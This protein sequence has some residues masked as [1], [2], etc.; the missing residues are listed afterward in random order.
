MPAS[1]VAGPIYPVHQPMAGEGEA[2]CDVRTA[3]DLLVASAVLCLVAVSAAFV[4]LSVRRLST[5]RRLAVITYV[6][7]VVCYS[8]FVAL[9]AFRSA[10]C[11]SSTDDPPTA[12]LGP[13]LLGVG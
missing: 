6:V 2:M 13:A 1:R 8:G 4:C 7:G 12:R 5:W 10:G 3:A 11:I 9:A